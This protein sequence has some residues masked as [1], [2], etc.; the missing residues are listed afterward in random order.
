[1]LEFGARHVAIATGSTWRRDGV[2]RDS[3]F[4]VPGFDGAERLHARRPDDR[5]RSRREGPVIVWDDDHYYMGGVLAE[6]CRDA[7]LEVTLVTPAA[8]V[9]AWTVNTLEALPIAKRIARL[10][11][12]V[13]PYTS[14]DWLRRTR[15]C[16]SST[17]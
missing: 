7:G 3:G 17:D 6:L 13:V 5:P 12:E 15:A 16:R 14:V 2:G 9:S 1:M 4:A 10:G 11:I 8:M